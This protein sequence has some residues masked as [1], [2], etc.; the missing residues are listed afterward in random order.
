VSDEAPHTDRI[1][2]LMPHMRRYAKHLC[3]ATRLDHR[4]VVQGALAAALSK[5]AAFRGDHDD[6]RRWLLATTRIEFF[7]QLKP[8]HRHPTSWLES[9]E[10][11]AAPSADDPAM[12]LAFKEAIGGLRRLGSQRGGR[13][14]RL[15]LLGT[16]FGYSGREMAAALGCPAAT[17]RVLTNRA[18]GKLRAAMG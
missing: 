7:H 2:E 1:I 3:R 5:R 6:L 17:V 13:V 9:A 12:V 15:G 14:E 10:V 4:D 11:L 18:R 8:Y 16:A